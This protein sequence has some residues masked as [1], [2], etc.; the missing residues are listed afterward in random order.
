MMTRAKKTMQIESS[1]LKMSISIVIKIMMII[2]Q[3][4]SVD[5]RVCGVQAAAEDQRDA[6][7]FAV[8]MIGGHE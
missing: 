7:P 8:E 1:R 6:Q 2:F 3:M 4:S 5:V